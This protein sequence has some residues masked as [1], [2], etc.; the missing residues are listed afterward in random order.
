MKFDYM[1]KY[2]GVYYNAGEDVPTGAS[3]NAN[4]KSEEPKAEPIVEEK[5][6]ATR[7]KKSE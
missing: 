6:K 3:S 2:N 7:K 4:V 1:V 5:P